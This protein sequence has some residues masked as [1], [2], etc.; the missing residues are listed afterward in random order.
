M[1]KF[2][3]LQSEHERLKQKYFQER[4]KGQ[5]LKKANQLTADR[6]S[7]KSSTKSVDNGSNEGPGRWFSES[8]RFSKQDLI[9]STE[10]AAF[11]E[12]EDDDDYRSGKS[13][14]TRRNYCCLLHSLIILFQNLQLY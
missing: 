12:E 10:L 1:D 8:R 2:D 9:N 13:C 6:R 4:R 3:V 7:R 14:I 5:R 11:S